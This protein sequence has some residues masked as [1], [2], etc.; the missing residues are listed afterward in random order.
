M[1][2]ER[3]FSSPMNFPDNQ[4]MPTKIFGEEKK[5]D[6][7]KSWTHSFIISKQ[8]EGKIRRVILVSKDIICELKAK[9]LDIFMLKDY[10]TGKIQKYSASSRIQGKY[11]MDNVDITSIISCMIRFVEA[12]RSLGPKSVRG[13]LLHSFA[14]TKNSVIILLQLSENILSVVDSDWRINIKPKNA[15]PGFLA[16]SRDSWDRI[17]NFVSIQGVQVT[18]KTLLALAGR[19]SYEEN[20]SR[21]FLA[22]TVVAT[23][24]KRYRGSFGENIKSKL[25]PYIGALWR[26]FE[27]IFRTN[28]R[29]RIKNFRNHWKWLNQEKL[30]IKHG[31]Y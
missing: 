9:S 15:E 10:E 20:T 18:G 4:L 2:A 24:H 12:K 29:R 28:T 7:T 8:F 5:N 16:L 22:E 19:W 21:F 31:L 17:S 14:R 11:V 26:L 3:E 23:L 13:C 27:F 1:K 25:N 6:S 30:V